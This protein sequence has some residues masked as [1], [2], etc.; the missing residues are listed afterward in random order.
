MAKRRLAILRHAEEI[1]GNVLDR[2]V[3]RGQLRGTLD[4]MRAL[5]QSGERGDPSQANRLLGAPTTTL[6]QWCEQRRN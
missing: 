6:L 3:L 1:T 5:Q 2:M 4:L